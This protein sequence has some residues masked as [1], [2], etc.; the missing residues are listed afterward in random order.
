[1]KRS[2]SYAILTL[3]LILAA[4]GSGEEEVGAGAGD[5]AVIP[6]G[7]GADTAMGAGAV[8]TDTGM[9]G[10][11]NRVSMMA[12]NNSGVTGEAT[13]TAQGEQTQVMLRVTGAPPNSTHPAHIHQGTCENQ[14][15]VVAPLQSVTVDA[16]GTGT[17]TSTVSVPLATVMNGQHYVQAHAANGGQPVACGNIPQ[18]HAG[19]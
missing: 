17:S 5:T 10:M 11:E 2:R 3:P 13:F 19:H 12:M 18:G 14:G 1:M 15:P 16:S 4:C 9:A 8:P 6:A 7:T